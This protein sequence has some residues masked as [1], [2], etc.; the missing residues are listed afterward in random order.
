MLPSIAAVQILGS[1]SVSYQVP[2]PIEWQ[3][4]SQSVKL[5]IE[6]VPASEIF[7][8]ARPDM[9]RVLQSLQLA[10]AWDDSGRLLR[11]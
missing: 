3:I 1:A 7:E 2:K 8:E 11:S 9:D 10:L 4:E 6:R 5:V